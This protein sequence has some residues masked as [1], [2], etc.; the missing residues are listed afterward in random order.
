MK[1]DGRDSQELQKVGVGLFLDDVLTDIG[2]DSDDD[3]ALGVNENG[4]D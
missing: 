1:D 2:L 3:G 4:K